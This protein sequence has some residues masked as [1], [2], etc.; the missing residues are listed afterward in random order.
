MLDL[1]APLSDEELTTQYSELMSPL[2]WDLAHCAH[3]EELWLIRAL[4]GSPLAGRG[5]DRPYNAIA[6][7]RPEGAAIG[8]LA[9]PQGPRFGPHALARPPA[10]ADRGPPAA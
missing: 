10:T 4:G 3:F 7:K 6:P 9:P 8:T 1:L 2:V 5:P